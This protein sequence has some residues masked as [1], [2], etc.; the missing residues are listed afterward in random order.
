ME[1]STLIMG[2]I[3]A[4]HRLVVVM[5]LP[6]ANFKDSKLP[7]THN[8]YVIRAWHHTENTGESTNGTTVVEDVGVSVKKAEAVLRDVVLPATERLARHKRATFEGADGDVPLELLE[9]EPGG[10]QGKEDS[11]SHMKGAKKRKREAELEGG[12]EATYY[13]RNRVKIAAN[14]K[15]KREAEMTL[16]EREEKEPKKA[17]KGKARVKRK[18]SKQWYDEFGREKYKLSGRAEVRKRALQEGKLAIA[19]FEYNGGGLTKIPASK[20]HPNGQFEIRL[21]IWGK[22]MKLSSHPNIHVAMLVSNMF[23]VLTDQCEKVKLIRFKDWA[24]DR[25]AIQH[26]AHEFVRRLLQTPNT[27]TALEKAAAASKIGAKAPNAPPKDMALC[28]GERK[29]ASAQKRSAVV[30][31]GKQTSAKKRRR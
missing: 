18:K 24:L 15:R 30:Q 11:M 16:E 29:Q 5:K 4:G 13:Q 28:A 21:R 27:R 2:P 23:K 19:R 14:Y 20:D 8:C 3:A 1:A 26:Q 25:E 22:L 31:E 17:R 12:E 7:I 6:D 10:G 9:Y